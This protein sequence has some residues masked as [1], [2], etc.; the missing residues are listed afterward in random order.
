M[1]GEKE[2]GNKHIQKWK[3][4][5]KIPGRRCDNRAIA[6]RSVHRRSRGT[7]T[8]PRGDGYYRSPAAC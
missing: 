2:N 6:R 4:K 7:A 3:K 1:A 5:W 8:Q